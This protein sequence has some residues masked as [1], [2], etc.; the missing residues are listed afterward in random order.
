MP[1]HGLEWFFIGVIVLILVL[2]D[3]QKIPKLARALAEAKREYEEATST[4]QGLIE[5]VQGKIEETSESDE[6]LIKIAKEL[7]IETYG[8]TREEIRDAIL[9][10]AGEKDQAP[11]PEEESEKTGEPEGKEEPKKHEP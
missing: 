5:E 9:K 8:K 11:K 3:P 2:W 6:T 1:I 4:V 7:G 10:K